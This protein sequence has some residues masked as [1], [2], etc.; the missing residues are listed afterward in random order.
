[1]K[2]RGMG[3]DMKFWNMSRVAKRFR[4]PRR[5]DRRGITLIELMITISIFGI[6][7]GVI[8]SFMTQ[9]SRSYQDSRERVQYQ[10]SLRAVLSLMTREVR[11]AGC[12]PEDVGFETL[13]LADAS[14]IRCQ[15]D[16][17]GDRDTGD[18]SPDENVTYSYN[19]ATGEFSR[20]DGS[21]AQVILR[22]LTAA[23][24]NYFDRDGAALA[25]VPLSATD[26]ASV[27]FVAID[28]SGETPSGEPVQYQTQV[29]IRNF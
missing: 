23:S 13:L 2:H 29:H 17:N 7:M 27:A 6:I 10:Q 11:S 25:G 21:G 26:R 3:A 4:R 24:F 20:D 22:G 1:M 28:L 12:D 5:P 18:N 14:Q 9:S 8:F 19:A 15:M 16:L